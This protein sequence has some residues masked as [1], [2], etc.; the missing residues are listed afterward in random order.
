V[1]NFAQTDVPFLRKFKT[2]L[3]GLA[4][5]A[6]FSIGHQRRGYVLS[7][8]R[9]RLSK[10]I[11]FRDDHPF[12]RSEEF[13]RAWRLGIPKAFSLFELWVFSFHD[14]GAELAPFSNGTPAP[15]Q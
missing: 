11:H 8:M 3:G 9:V 4:N 2:P 15:E 13:E 14:S 10:G 12:F 1:F 6:A 5:Y 7:L